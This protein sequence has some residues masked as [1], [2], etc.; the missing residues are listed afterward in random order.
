MMSGHS[1]CEAFP[2]VGLALAAGAM[3]V[4]RVL[5]NLVLAAPT[6]G[7]VPLSVPWAGAA[8]IA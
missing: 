8:T 7:A 3:T 5:R 2:F 1:A 6:L 4:P